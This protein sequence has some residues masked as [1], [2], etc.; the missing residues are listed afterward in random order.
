[1]KKTILVGIAILAV[2]TSA[3]F[4]AKKKPAAQPQV[5]AATITPVMMPNGGPTAAEKAL[6]KKNQHDAGMKK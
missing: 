4:A 2:S 3:A 1:V 6:Y 5:A